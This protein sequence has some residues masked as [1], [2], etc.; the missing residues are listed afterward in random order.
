MKLGWFA[1][2]QKAVWKGLVTWN[3]MHPSWRLS[4]RLWWYKL[5]WITVCTVIWPCKSLFLCKSHALLMVSS[6][7]NQT[8]LFYRAKRVEFN[9]QNR[10]AFLLQ[11][12][13]IL[14]FEMRPGSNPRWSWSTWHGR[15]NI[16]HTTRLCLRARETESAISSTCAW[17]PIQN[18]S[19][20]WIG[21][22]NLPP[23]IA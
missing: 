12:N 19:V 8:S 17:N 15:L 9:N 7:W 5:L 6:S 4:L 10:A 21:R 11:N 23:G 3:L 13:A 20:T 14:L 16:T 22:V 18:V 1:A 2:T